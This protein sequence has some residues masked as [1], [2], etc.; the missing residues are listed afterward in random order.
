MK[1]KIHS[2]SFFSSIYMKDIYCFEKCLAVFTIIISRNYRT[3]VLFFQLFTDHLSVLRPPSG[4]TRPCSVSR[5]RGWSHSTVA[6]GLGSRRAP[7]PPLGPAGRAYPA[8][9][10]AAPRPGDSTSGY[11]PDT[12]IWASWQPQTLR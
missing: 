10:G 9:A 4:G 3:K 5:N 12:R 1:R 2:T 7:F 8:A 6:L 11:S